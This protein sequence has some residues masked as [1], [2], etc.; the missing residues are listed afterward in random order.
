[1]TGRGPNWLGLNVF[2]S[3]DTGHDAE[4]NEDVIGCVSVV[5]KGWAMDRCPLFSSNPIRDNLRETRVPVWLNNVSRPSHRQSKHVSRSETE[6]EFGTSWC[7]PVRKA[8]VDHALASSCF[9]QQERLDREFWTM[10][11]L[12][13]HGMDECEG[14]AAGLVDSTPFRPQFLVVLF[15]K[16]GRDEVLRPRS[17]KLIWDSIDPKTLSRVVTELSFS[18][19]ITQLLYRTETII[20]SYFRSSI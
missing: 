8:K 9:C 3:V 2:A 4:C 20:L 7:S 16:V 15:N 19:K 14:R 5:E 1:M 18:W 12:F 11:K 13:I 6:A 10:E 17:H